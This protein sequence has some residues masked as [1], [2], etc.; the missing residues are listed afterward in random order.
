M[1]PFQGYFFDDHWDNFRNCS[2]DYSVGPTEIDRHAVQDMGLGADEVKEIR[3][4]FA[5]TMDKVYEKLR[6]KKLWA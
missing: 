2:R 1:S 6:A 3:D 5:W 4:A